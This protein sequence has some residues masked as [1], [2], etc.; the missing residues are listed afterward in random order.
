MVG[1]EYQK[2][3]TGLGWVVFGVCIR[4]GTE[5]SQ[6]FHVKSAL[7]IDMTDFWTTEAMGIEGK[8]CSCKVVKR[9]SMDE[10]EA[11]IIEDSCRKVGKQWLT[12]YPWIKD[13]SEQ[14]DNKK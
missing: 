7:P 4:V 12:P 9:S 1:I 13:P 5:V 3:H 2:L 11:K 8:R 14:P 10:C 6:V